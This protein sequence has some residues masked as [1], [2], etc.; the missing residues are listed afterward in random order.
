MSQRGITSRTYRSDEKT[1]FAVGKGRGWKWISEV[2]TDPSKMVTIDG[3]S[4]WCKR[5]ADKES[6]V[7]ERTRSFMEAQFKYG[8]CHIDGDRVRVC[9]GRLKRTVLNMGIG[10]VGH[11]GELYWKAIRL[12]HHGLDM[13]RWFSEVKLSESEETAIRSAVEDWLT[14]NWFNYLK[15]A[16]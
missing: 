16:A 3:W 10:D 13:W 4:A 5:M 7:V 1:S 6:R 9:E 8:Y 12:T 15:N 11:A 14:D 2:E